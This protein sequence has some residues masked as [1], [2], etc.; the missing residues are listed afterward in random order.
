M[1]AD[2][3]ACCA[4]KLTQQEQRT[5]GQL[6]KLVAEAA[7]LGGIGPAEELPPATARALQEL[8]PSALQVSS[9]GQR[10]SLRMSAIPR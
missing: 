7:A 5:A 3:W 4:G 6:R 9:L 8:C 10:S 1:R 2:T